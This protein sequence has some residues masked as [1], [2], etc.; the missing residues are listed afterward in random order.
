MTNSFEF[1][2]TDPATTLKP[3]K[4]PYIRSRCMLGRNKREGSRRSIR[5]K[6]TKEI[7]NQIKLHVESTV[8]ASINDLWTIKLPSPIDTEARGILFRAVAFA[9]S[10]ASFSPLDRYVDFDDSI[11]SIFFDSLFTDALCLH[12]V[13]STAY[14]VADLS[15][16]DCNG[17]PSRKVSSH[18]RETLGLLARKMDD[19]K[20]AQDESILFV[21]LNLA[22]LAAL[23]GDWMAAAAHYAGLQRIIQLRGGLQFVRARPKLFLK[24]CRYVRPL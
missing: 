22:L 24:L 17:L 19:A 2:A 13:L 14:A 9:T 6:K 15:K 8:P 7:L 1:I 21:V 4:N 20:A 3:G 12:S 23:Y 18:L 16:P 11:E 5:E 10:G